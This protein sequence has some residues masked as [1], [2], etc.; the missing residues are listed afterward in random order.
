[1]GIIWGLTNLY[2]PQGLRPAWLHAYYRQLGFAPSR[3][4]RLAP[5]WYREQLQDDNFENPREN[6]K[7]QDRIITSEEKPKK[8]HPSQQNRKKRRPH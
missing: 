1:M 5:A 4:T 6:Q 7:D 8:S 2:Y 3:G